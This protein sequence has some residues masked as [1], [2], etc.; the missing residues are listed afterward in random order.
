MKNRLS[1]AERKQRKL[2]KINSY[3]QIINNNLLKY[4]DENPANSEDDDISN[5][6]DYSIRQSLIELIKI[7]P[8]EKQLIIEAANTV[9]RGL[10]V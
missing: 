1:R 8:Q 4:I 7:N 10:M 5:K 6:V 9:V 2:D 3:S